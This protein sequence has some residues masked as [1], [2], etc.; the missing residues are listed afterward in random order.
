VTGGNGGPGGYDLLLDYIDLV[1]ASQFEAENLP[2]TGT[3]TFKPVLDRH[4]SGR[5]GILFAGKEVGDYISFNVEVPLPGTY[6]V[7]AGVRRGPRNGTV[8]L[9]IDDTNQGLPRDTYSAEL[10]YAVVDFGTVAFTEAGEKTF[11]FL[12]TGRDPQSK[13]Y[14]FVLDYL[15]LVR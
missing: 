5:T 8:Q 7:K 4:L 12:I 15:N 6:R 1:A 9:A 13:D 11:Q 2:V 3:Q 10:D 14:Q